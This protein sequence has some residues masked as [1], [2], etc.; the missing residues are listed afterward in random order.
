MGKTY[1]EEM[2]HISST[3]PD[4]E[5]WLLSVG[6]KLELWVSGIYKIGAILESTDNTSSSIENKLQIKVTK[7]TTVELTNVSQ[8]KQNISNRGN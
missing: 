5:S 6:N 1:K 4:K 2:K 8:R 7:T 3:V